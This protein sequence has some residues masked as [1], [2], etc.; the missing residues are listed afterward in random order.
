MTEEQ[1]HE[2][3]ERKCLM[4]C[5]HRALPWWLPCSGKERRMSRPQWDGSI[6]MFEKYC[7]G[8]LIH[9]QWMFACLG[10]W[11]PVIHHPWHTVQTSLLRHCLWQV[12]RKTQRRK[13]GSS[14]Y[15]RLV[16]AEQSMRQLERLKQGGLRLVAMMTTK[17][18]DKYLLQPVSTQMLI[19]GDNLMH[20]SCLKPLW[21]VELFDLLKR[22]LQSFCPAE[23]TVWS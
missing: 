1:S 17:T 5:S 8:S 14:S 7:G 20:V 21:V 9:S 11:K 13:L 6:N 3:V 23:S 16:L 12:S 15:C 19:V 18:N 22:Q 10:V 4:S 2:A